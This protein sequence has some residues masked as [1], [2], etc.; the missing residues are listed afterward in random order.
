MLIGHKAI[1]LVLL[2]TFTYLYCI[3]KSV[4]ENCH[5]CFLLCLFLTCE[6][7]VYVFSQSFWKWMYSIIV[8]LSVTLNLEH[9]LSENPVASAQMPCP[10]ERI[11]KGFIIMWY[12]RRKEHFYVF[13]S[14]QTT[15]Q[16]YLENFLLEILFKQTRSLFCTIQHPWTWGY[17]KSGS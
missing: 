7:S 17:S 11:K 14:Q 5:H 3:F 15:L 6:A 13:T 16:N 9:F 2:K 4:R 8:T 10:V 12:I 1:C